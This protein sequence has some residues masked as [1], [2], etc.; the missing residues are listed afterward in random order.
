MK[1]NISD[2]TED[3]IALFAQYPHLL[4]NLMG[5]ELL[6]EMHSQWIRYLWL[7]PKSSSLQAHRGSYKTTACT[8]L[9]IV[10]WLLFNP[11]EKMALIRQNKTAA[12]DTLKAVTKYFK[13]PVVQEVFRVAHGTYPVILSEAYGTLDMSFK[14]SISKEHTVDA[15]GIDSVPTGSHYNRIIC[16][17]VIVHEDRLS[18]ARRERTKEGLREVYTNIIN[19]GCPVLHIGTP[20][21]AEDGWNTPTVP[22]P[23][24]FDITQTGLIPP[25]EALEIRSKTTASL[26][27]ANY[28]LKHMSDEEQIFKDPTYDNWKFSVDGTVAHLDA[29]FSGDHTGALT[30]MTRLPN[31]KIQVKGFVFH[32]NVKDMVGFIKKEY[33]RHRCTKLFLETNPDQGYTSQLLSRKDEH[34]VGLNTE[35][36][37]ESM[38][39]HNKIVTYGLEF[40]K[41]LV[42]DPSMMSSEPG[43]EKQIEYMSQLMDYSEK[44]EPDDAADSLASL[45]RQGFSGAVIKTTTLALYG[46]YGD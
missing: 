17:D 30:F 5:M 7:S 9:G 45:L 28:L 26:Y 21:H 20:W 14:T 13:H 36:Y 33:R 15:H 6:T 43:Y 39:K 22:D 16:D 31:G 42:F 18:K 34:G 41:D 24:M 8:E 3:H 38:N 12:S 35:D 2:I 46:D 44:E 32:E 40:W 19:R 1:S 11:D 10:W 25:E 23:V 4:G 37:R 29:K 27:A